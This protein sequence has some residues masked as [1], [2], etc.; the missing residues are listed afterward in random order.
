MS[1]IN[2]WINDTKV[3]VKQG[4]TILDAA[5]DIGIYIP[6]LCARKGLLPFDLVKPVSAVYRGSQKT[7]S[8]CDDSYQGCG[9][10]A[11]AVEDEKN[12][13]F[14][15]HKVAEENMRVSTVSDDLLEYRK[16]RLAKILDHH[17]H[18]C[19][20]CAQNEG[21]SLTQCSSNVPEQE[22]CCP[23]FNRC[24]L[25]KVSEFVGI[26]RN[27]PKYVFKDLPIVK[28]EPL[29][30]RDYN[31]CIGCTRCIRACSDQSENAAIGF[32]NI[33]GKIVVG[34]IGPTPGESGCRFCGK[35]VEVCPTGALTDKNIKWV[36]RE[37]EL[38]PCKNACP[39]G[40]DIPDYI[41]LIAQENFSQ[42]ARIIRAKTPLAGVLG[43]VCFHPCEAEC[44]RGE[45]SDPMSICALKRFAMEKDNGN[46]QYILPAVEPSGKR[47]A[48]IGGGPAGLSAAYWLSSKGHKATIFEAMP[49]LGG[50]LRYGIPR[51]RL[52][53]DLLD[54]EIKA[55]TANDLVEIKTNST[56]EMSSV[57]KQKFD[58]VLIT[59]G[60]QSGK[61]LPIKQEAGVIQGIKFLRDVSA[62]VISN[63]HFENKSVAVIGGGNVAMDTAR[64]A[65]RMGAKSV[66]IVCLES[67]SEMPAHDFE[68]DHAKE[69]GIG[70]FPSCGI[71]SIS[72]GTK[73][74]HSL[75]LVEC[76]SVFDDEGIFCPTFNDDVA[77]QIE[78]DVII[79]AIGQESDFSFLS[80]DYQKI[81]SKG[82]LKCDFKTMALSI[83]DFYGAGEAATGPSSVVEAI[84]SGKQAAGAIDKSFGGSGEFDTL[85][86]PYSDSTDLGKIEGFDKLK[87]T[88]MANLSPQTRVNN[89]DL[90]ETGFNQEAAIAEAKRCLECDL[91]FRSA[92][93]A[94]P[95][96]K[97]LAFTMEKIETVPQVEGVFQLLGTDKDILSIT[98]TPNLRQELTEKFDDGSQAGFFLFDLDPMYT[99]RESELIQQ[100]MQ[101]HGKMPGG[102]DD[103]LDDLF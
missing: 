48:I 25:K 92:E 20:L 11:V 5:L 18:A 61:T 79:A 57:V 62:K 27:L 55:I 65:L 71:K 95:P 94:L 86:P 4:A 2:I 80:D 102:D 70:F 37:S 35:C 82:L 31:L 7:E 36:S 15:C 10:C 9:L 29:F 91:R 63:D 1:D 103:D 60:A 41:R 30:I 81:I 17:P 78:A 50:M 32:V 96:E 3:T 49:R 39:V 33:D 73:A 90:I 75:G 6:H 93:I 100:Y 98:G 14:S 101:E 28:D 72:K 26:A 99:K 76:S 13:V 77:S 44:R 52:T 97:W 22:R 84:A 8:V 59:V 58:S 45:V 85:S 47:V 74:E 38:L 21:C 19:L 34:A 89:F 16:K 68:I 46:A 87:R 67:D 83:S 88:A 40:L 53:E 24:E 64:T 51:Y 43:M 54:N 56:V 23:Q 66:D 69:E 42:A 12:F